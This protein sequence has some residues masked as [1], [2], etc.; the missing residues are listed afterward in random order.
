MKSTPTRANPSIYC[1]AARQD[2]LQ[3]GTILLIPAVKAPA[4]LRFAKIFSQ[5]HMSKKTFF[6]RYKQ[7]P[8]GKKAK[9][10]LLRDALTA[11]IEDGYWKDYEQLPTETEL[12]NLTPFSLG[13]VQRAIR[14][15]V[16]DGTVQRKRGL[17]TFVVPTHRRMGGPWFWQHLTKDES[18]FEIMTTLVVDRKQVDAEQASSPLIRSNSNADYLQIDRIVHAGEM[19]FVSR[20]L[21]DCKRFPL[22]KRWPIGKLNGAN[23]YGLIRKHYRVKADVISRTLRCAPAPEFVS[24]LLK[25]KRNEWSVHMEIIGNTNAGDTIFYNK[26]YLPPGETKMFFQHPGL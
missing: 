24:N 26:I 13:T 7:S 16:E 25:R 3:C 8:D 11:A 21:V 17:G 23:F 18:S 5:M 10:E 6:D 12:T 15:L 1:V 14:S 2:T 22:F 20:Y 9:H 4:K 19:S